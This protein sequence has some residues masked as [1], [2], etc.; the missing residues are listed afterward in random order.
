[1]DLEYP[2][3]SAVWEG[4]SKYFRERDACDEAARSKA[5][6]AAIGTPK[7]SRS[8]AIWTS[9]GRRESIVTSDGTFC[10]SR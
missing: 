7:T 4:A 6:E 10:L 8:E 1:M 5:T 2:M 9:P 3:N